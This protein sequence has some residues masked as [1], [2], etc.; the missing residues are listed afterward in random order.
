MS[1]GWTDECGVLRCHNTL[2]GRDHDRTHEVKDS[3]QKEKTEVTFLSLDYNGKLCVNL[4][5][6]NKMGC[7]SS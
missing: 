5:K 4:E 6:I 2:H 3:Y 7:K 1:D